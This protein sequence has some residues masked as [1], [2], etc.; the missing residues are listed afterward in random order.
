EI[1]PAIDKNL[2][3]EE[4]AKIRGSHKVWA[5]KNYEVFIAPTA[6]IPSII[7]EIG[8]LREITFREVGE[9]TNKAIDLDSYD[10]YYNHLF[11]W[12]VETKMVVGAYRIGKGDEIF[13]SFGKKGFYT[14]ELFKIK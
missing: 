9:G 5:E 10:I 2:M 1:V 11:I 3:E 7:K 14:Y 12:D 8:R 13:Y 6:F 4:V